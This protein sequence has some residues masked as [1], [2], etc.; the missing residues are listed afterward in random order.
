MKKPGN[1]RL[2]ILFFRC[3]ENKKPLTDIVQSNKQA[4]TNKHCDI[5]LNVVCGIGQNVN[6]Q[7]FR[8]AVC[9]KIAQTDINHKKWQR[10]FCMA[11]APKR[12]YS[13]QKIAEN[14]SKKIV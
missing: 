1:A 8:Q 2:L 7:R 3:F 10:L 12:K 5:L 14:A 11:I 4:H 6:D 13:I 9:Q